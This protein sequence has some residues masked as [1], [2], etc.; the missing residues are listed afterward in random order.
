MK[1][2]TLLIF[3]WYPQIW[4]KP[5]STQL[6]TVKWRPFVKPGKNILIK[7]AWACYSLNCCHGIKLQN[8]CQ[9]FADH[10][11]IDKK[12]KHIW[13]LPENHL[14]TTSSSYLSLLS[15]LVQSP[16]L[17]LTQHF[18]A[19]LRFTRLS[20]TRP[21]L[22]EPPFQ[23]CTRV[24]L[25]VEAVCSVYLDM[26][27]DK[28]NTAN[29]ILLP[30]SCFHSA[31]LCILPPPFVPSPSAEGVRGLSASISAGPL[32]SAFWSWGSA[33]CCCCSVSHMPFIGGGCACTMLLVRIWP[34][35]IF[36][37]EDGASKEQYEAGRLVW[38]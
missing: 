16:L 22:S 9:K 30:P 15:L 32:L 21:C 2:T 23:S 3:L 8:Q 12:T 29:R 25:C 7:G 1:F 24:A 37:G 14:P 17:P 33:A 13:A 35:C 26:W 4:I 19:W 5:S 27:W 18:T 11:F 31:A 34:K 28:I 10:V 20:F 36:L 6:S 38:V